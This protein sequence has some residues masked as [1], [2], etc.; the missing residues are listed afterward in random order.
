MWNV[1]NHINKVSV[2]QLP[3]KIDVLYAAQLKFEVDTM[4]DKMIFAFDI[5]QKL[6]FF[7]C[8]LFAM[9]F[10]KAI[11][12]DAVVDGGH[13]W[14]HIEPFDLAE[15]FSFWKR[16]EVGTIFFLYKIIILDVNQSGHN[17]FA[18]TINVVCFRFLSYMNGLYDIFFYL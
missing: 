6:K 13:A 4:I 7:Q 12:V 18:G 3:Y 15:C 1:G 17:D 5:F 16:T 2:E 8:F 14:E 10:Q 9:F 11:H